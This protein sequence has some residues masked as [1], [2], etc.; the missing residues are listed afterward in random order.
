[1]T[2]KDQQ[3]EQIEALLTKGIAGLYPSKDFIKERLL[4]GKELTIYLGVDPTGPTLHLGHAIPLM[5]LREF[6][7]LGHQVVFLIGD[8]TAMIGD[9]TDKGA[10]RKQLT[11]Q[12]VKKNLTHYTKQAS[13]ILSFTG[14]N[15][16]VVK[17]NATWHQK[18]RFEQ[19]LNLASHMT[20]QQMI[21]RDM[22]EK[23]IT[24]GKPIYLHEF[25]YPLM[26]GYDSVALATDGE[27]GGNDQTFNMLAGRT[28][29]K[30]M[31]G[32]EKFVI[33]MKLLADPT[34]KKMGKTEGNMITLDD[35]PN[36]MFGKVMSWTDGM[37]L[38]AFELC[39]TKTLQEIKNIETNL[40]KGILHPKDA[41]ILLAKEIVTMYHGAIKANAAEKY[42]LE[43][44][45]QKKAP[46]TV[47]KIKGTGLLLD[48]L[49]ANGCVKSKSEARR[50]FEANAVTDVLT[51]EKITDPL[52]QI[53]KPLNL[54]IG[55]HTFIKIQPK[56]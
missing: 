51:N 9:P 37:I 6:Q 25:L 1:M 52:Y 50:L 42:F 45:Q 56:K 32:K 21:E 17:H 15:K 7:E 19:V 47:P 39:T 5:K 30:E 36:E 16:V 22:F 4:S 55:K 29:M 33:T 13:K 8:F 24:E 14:K 41:K 40:I 18:L 28:L 35:T 31:L 3:K 11:K 48:V 34:G 23:R 27:I 20:V 38:Q 12:E 10:T 49:V 2:K 26:Q 44:F 43:T 53:H 46:E 54:R